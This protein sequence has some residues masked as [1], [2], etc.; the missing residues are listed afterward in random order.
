MVERN[1]VIWF[2]R[3]RRECTNVDYSDPHTGAT[4]AEVYK[5][6][7]DAKVYKNRTNM[8]FID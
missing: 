3:R 8:I 2:E 1:V 7:L 6:P 5:G 4:Q